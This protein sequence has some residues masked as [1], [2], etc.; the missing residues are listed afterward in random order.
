MP[1][2]S[3][4]YWIIAGY[5]SGSLAWGYW[6][7]KYI[8]RVD[9]RTKGSGNIGATNVFRVL[10]PAPGI[11]TF[12]LDVLKGALPVMFFNH[13]YGK[14][15]NLFLLIAIGFA[16]IIGSKFSIFLKG[17]GGKAVN[18]SLGVILAIVPREALISLII[19]VIIF[20]TTGY[21]SLASI[22]AAACLPL[23]LWF[24]K[25]NIVIVILGILIFL[26]IISAHR[27]NIKRLVHGKENRFKIWKK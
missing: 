27:E 24:L 11:F 21:V 22:S 17:K 18:C 14:E 19:W 23:L 15:A 26:V 20:L 7:A 3:I 1:L 9:L 5:I 13:T 2:V 16:S 4:I 6:I 10:G 25:E 12:I 8:Y